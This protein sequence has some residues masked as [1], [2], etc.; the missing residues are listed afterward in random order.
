MTKNDRGGD[1]LDAWITPDRKA[2]K[3]TLVCKNI[4]LYNYTKLAE[5][6][7]SDIN[8][9]HPDWEIT[10]AGEALLMDSMID[11]L[12][13]TQTQS[14]LITFLLIALSLVILFKSFV[15]GIFSTLPIVIGACFIAGFMAAFGITINLVTVIVI[16]CCIGIG[17]D[18]AIHF[19][20]SF[21]RFRQ[22]GAENVEALLNAL[23]DKGTVIILN[24]L[25]V[26]VGFLVLCFS[27]FPPVRALGFLIFLSMTVGSAFS[28]LFLPVFLNI[29]KKL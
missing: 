29:K 10:A 2:V 12:I 24:T 18:Y 21:L 11:L 8:Q 19:T 16:T 28:L 27:K 17:I 26:G 25:A 5:K 15:I 1:L 3:I 20:S 22:N 13:K 4:Q 9:T 7:K 23:Q 14:L 6:L